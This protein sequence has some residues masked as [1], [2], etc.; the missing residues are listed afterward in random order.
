MAS[1]SCERGDRVYTLESGRTAGTLESGQT[2]ASQSVRSEQGA[3]VCSQARGPAQQQAVRMCAVCVC[4][5]HQ[6]AHLRRPRAHLRR[7][8][9]LKKE[10]GYAPHV[11]SPN[12]Y[13]SSPWCVI[14]A[15]WLGEGGGHARV[16]VTAPR[17]TVLA[18]GVLGTQ[19]AQFAIQLV[20]K[21]AMNRCTH[22]YVETG[23]PRKI[24]FPLVRQPAEHG[25]MGSA[26]QRTVRRT[27]PRG[28]RWHRAD[29]RYRCHRRRRRCAGG[30]ERKKQRW[31]RRSSRPAQVRTLV[32]TLVRTPAQVR[33]PAR[34]R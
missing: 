17:A 10:P 22:A 2:A 5:K 23:S 29:P 24:P 11:P 8:L 27:P 20:M 3:R 4:G 13:S 26:R 30:R 19:S 14:S 28:S 31:T 1:G 7:A 9:A 21:T 33:T 34:Q 6:R 15:V 32:R 25:H 12:V 18:R 16:C